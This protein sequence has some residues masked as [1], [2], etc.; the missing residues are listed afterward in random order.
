M[1]EHVLQTRTQ[2]LGEDH[3]DTIGAEAGL[4]STLRELVELDQAGEMAEHVVQA[5]IRVVGEDHPRNPRGQGR[6]GAATAWAGR[7]P[8]NDLVAD[9]AGPGHC[10]QGPGR[11]TR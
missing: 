9:P 1:E 6:P 2:V 10:G 3:P 4:A 11:S 8:G 7:P 5:R